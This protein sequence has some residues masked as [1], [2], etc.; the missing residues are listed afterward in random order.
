MC[1][2]YLGLICPALLLL[3]L[4]L[5]HPSAVVSPLYPP[6]HT[7][8]FSTGVMKV[9]DPAGRNSWWWLVKQSQ[10]VGKHVCISKEIRTK[11][12]DV[13]NIMDA[14]QPK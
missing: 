10:G 9:G 3:L 6:L 2:M 11:K 12:K 8:R 5:I 7:P 13:I 4:L 14:G 1:E